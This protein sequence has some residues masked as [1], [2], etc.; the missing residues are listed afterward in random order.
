MAPGVC[1]P[2]IWKLTDTA[3]LFSS[4]RQCF[5]N[6]S[7]AKLKYLMP[8]SGYDSDLS[9]RLTP[10]QLVF[11]KCFTLLFIPFANIY[12]GTS[13]ILFSTNEH[14]CLNSENKKLPVAPLGALF[15]NFLEFLTKNRQFSF[16]FISF[17]PFCC[18]GSASPLISCLCDHFLSFNSQKNRKNQILK[19]INRTGFPPKNAYIQ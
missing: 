18:G 5:I 10:R 19:K 2:V 14:I 13:W 8:C 7:P 11:Y 1:D 16:Q 12:H 6:L 9:C 15:S 4:L 3:E 17:Y